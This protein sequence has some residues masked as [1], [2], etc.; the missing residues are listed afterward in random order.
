MNNCTSLPAADTLST[1]GAAAQ[2]GKATMESRQQVAKRQG[3]AGW[4]LVLKVGAGGT[5]VVHM[6]VVANTHRSQA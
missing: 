4:F 3:M 5:A 2:T 6:D 1:N